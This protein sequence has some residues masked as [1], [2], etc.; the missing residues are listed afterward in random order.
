MDQRLKKTNIEYRTRSSNYEGIPGLSFDI[1]YSLFDIRHSDPQKYGLL[2]STGRNFFS[3][4]FFSRGRC[5]IRKGLAKLVPGMKDDTLGV[6]QGLAVFDHLR[7]QFVIVG[8]AILQVWSRE[9][10][11]FELTLIG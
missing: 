3:R 11:V 9:N 8:L 10:R 4:C 6:G 7:S 1:Q 2:Q 5:Q